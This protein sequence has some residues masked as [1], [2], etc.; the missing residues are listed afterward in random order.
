MKDV[1]NDRE[2]NAEEY[3]P[4]ETLYFKTTDDPGSKEYEYGVYYER[5]KPERKNVYRK[6]YQQ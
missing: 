4:P 5:K 6:C 1:L 2:H 3:R